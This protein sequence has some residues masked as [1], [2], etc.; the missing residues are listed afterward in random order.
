MPSK[1]EIVEKLSKFRQVDKYTAFHEALP[2]VRYATAAQRHTV[3]DL[4]N[5]CAKELVWLFQS[6]KKMPRKTDMKKVLQ[7]HM[8]LVAHSALDEENKEFAYKLC[9]FL[10]EK[11]EVNLPKQ[12]AKKY[13]GYWQIVDNEVK[14]V[15]YRKPRK[16]I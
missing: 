1:E 6:A 14:T 11:V 10:A 15:K 13:W 16:M 9:W 7:I 2:E 4:L 5:N 3:T 8:N 12:T